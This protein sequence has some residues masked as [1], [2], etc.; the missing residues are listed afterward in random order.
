[1]GEAS[2]FPADA[3]SQDARQATVQAD[4]LFRQLDRSP[5]RYRDSSKGGY[6]RFGSDSYRPT[7]HSGNLSGRDGYHDPSSHP[8]SRSPS[9][10]VENAPTGPRGWGT[11]NNKRGRVDR[12][13]SPP[14][15]KQRVDSLPGVPTGPSTD[16]RKK[17]RIDND[18]QQAMASSPFIQRQGNASNE[19]NNARQ[20]ATAPSSVSSA[21]NQRQGN[22]S[23]GQCAV[24]SLHPS[25]I[26]Q[27]KLDLS[28]PRKP[29]APS[30][31]QRGNTPNMP[32]SAYDRAVAFLHPESNSMRQLGLSLTEFSI[33]HV[34][35]QAQNGKH[36]FNL[37]FQ[38]L[39]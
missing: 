22:P 23:K 4:Q 34:K 29:P 39:S 16:T 25:T 26:S 30:S 24:N 20:Q 18:R 28:L 11:Q 27:G 15:S 36:S 10:F 17:P 2:L 9:L 19:S 32:S 37:S 7:Y 31:S 6:N 5:G 33:Q 3:N 21:A 38:I 1:M 14:S 13:R 8:R 35:Y 12:T